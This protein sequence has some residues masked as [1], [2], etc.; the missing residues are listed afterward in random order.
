MEMVNII[1][2]IYKGPTNNRS[3]RLKF[4]TS[5]GYKKTISRDYSKNP[6]DDAIDFLKSRG[7][8]IIAFGY[9]SKSNIIGY[10][11]SDTFK[12]FEDGN[13]NKAI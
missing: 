2:I 1:E 8:N 5:V 7:F 9:S 11:V 6:M 3:S 10:I 13:N 4:I 12:G